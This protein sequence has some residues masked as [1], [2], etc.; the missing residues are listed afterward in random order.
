LNYPT[1]VDNEWDHRFEPSGDRLLE[2]I[3]FVLWFV[4]LI[5]I[6]L[7]VIGAMAFGADRSLGAYSLLASC[8][9]YPVVLA[10]SVILRKKLRRAVYLPALNAAAI[11]AVYAWGTL[12]RFQS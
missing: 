12:T 11:L 6:M 2:N 7:F 3:V 4:L 9:A 5:P 10:V 8:W 1:D